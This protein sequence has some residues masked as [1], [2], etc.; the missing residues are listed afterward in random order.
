MSPGGD[1]QQLRGT[2]VRPR[3][4]HPQHR[5]TGEYDVVEHAAGFPISQRVSNRTFEL[6]HRERISKSAV[7]SSTLRSKEPA[8]CRRGQPHAAPKKISPAAT[9]TLPATSTSSSAIAKSAPAAAASTPPSPFAR[10]D[11]S[12]PTLPYDVTQYLLDTRFQPPY[13]LCS[14]ASSFRSSFTRRSYVPRSCVPVAFCFRSSSDLL[15]L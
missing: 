6:V 11:R 10:L 2:K 8:R 7:P 13:G 12:H 9:S 15:C 14:A 3:K 1:A 4:L 5:Y